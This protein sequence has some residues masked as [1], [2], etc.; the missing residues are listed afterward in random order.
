MNDKTIGDSLSRFQ[1]ALQQA[2]SSMNEFISENYVGKWTSD[3]VYHAM[4]IRT[5]FV[6]SMHNYL[7]DKGLLNMERVSLSPVTDP[8]AHDI[9]HVPSIH[10]KGHAYKTTHSMIYSKFL[11]CFNPKAKGIFVDSPNIR[12]ELESVNRKQ[13]GKY[14]IDFSQMDIEF[15]RKHLITLDSYYNDN[16]EVIEK[17]KEDKEI[18]LS[19]FEE[20]IAQAVAEVVKKNEDSIR[21]LGVRMEV[22]SLPFPRIT[23]DEAHQRTGTN[24]FEQP[25]AK[26]MNGQFFW[27]TGLMRENYDLIYPYLK[28]DGT[29][30]PIGDF[31]SEDIYNYDLCAQSL[32]EDGSYGQCFEVMSGALREWLYEPIVERLVDNKIIKVEPKFS[33]GGELENLEE[34]GGYGPFLIAARMKDK[35]GAPLFPST[36]GGGLGIERSLFAMLNG[37]VITKV[38]EVTLFGKNPDSFPIY[39]Y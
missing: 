12:L 25:I 38:D 35:K 17:L 3:A 8:L 19:F 13:R 33:L 2:G 9:E 18:A 34:L 15:K 31:S 39:L 1:S 32:Q 10:Y 20:M 28:A 22:P 26:E 7:T 14:L 23:R 24:A 30:R 11:A 37:P 36:A 16:A 5:T 6:N 21:A 4:A 27:V 29:K